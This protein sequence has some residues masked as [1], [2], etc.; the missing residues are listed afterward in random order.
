MSQSD[1]AEAW[2]RLSPI[3]LTNHH[4]DYWSGCTSLPSHQ[5]WRS[6]SLAP[7]LC[8]TWQQELSLVL[9]ILVILRGVRWNLIVVL[10]CIS[11]L[12]ED[13]EY[14]K[15]YFSTTW[16][17]STGNSLFGSA[18]YFLIGLSVCLVNS[19]LGPLCIL[20]I[21]FLSDVEFVKIFSHSVASPVS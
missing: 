12:T 6:V 5:Q 8:S 1:I 10:I 9:L 17:L 11:M 14:F 15:K 16:I 13:L 18:P 2:S 20:D 21:S 19:F 4:I 7:H 3:F